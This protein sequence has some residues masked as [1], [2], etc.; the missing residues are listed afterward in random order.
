MG[1]KKPN[2]SARLKVLILDAPDDYSYANNNCPTWVS[3]LTLSNLL[4]QPFTRS[5]S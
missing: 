2:T 5:L 3:C 1:Q 4:M